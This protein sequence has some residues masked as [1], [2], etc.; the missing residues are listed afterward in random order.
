MLVVQPNTYFGDR[1]CE[2]LD[3]QTAGQSHWQTFEFAAAWINNSGAEKLLQSAHNFLARGGSIRA[4]VGLDFAS[5]SYEGLRSLLSLEDESV[6]I[7]TY[8]FYDENRACTFHPKVY[9]FSNSDVARLFVGSNNLTGGGLETNVEATLGFTSSLDDE[10]IRTAGQTLGAWRQDALSR[11][12]R[13]TLE[14]L[15]K[16]R[17]QGYVRTEEEIRISR[18]SAASPGATSREPLFG[19]SAASAGRRARSRASQEPGSRQAQGNVLEEVL[20]MRVRP[21]RNGGQFQI[22]MDVLNASFMNGATEVI[23]TDGSRR[24]IGYSIANGVRNTARFEAPE[25]RGMT[26]PVARFRRA[27]ASQS[28]S[29]GTVPLQYEI[30]DAAA[31]GEGARILR[32]LEEGIARPARTNLSELSRDETVLSK[33]DRSRAQWYRLDLN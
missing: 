10:T 24:Q 33:S 30:F 2:E 4:V 15:E 8:V 19:R 28:D 29:S 16:L 13:L 5:T 32:K 11:S 27:N 23:S 14:F 7:E 17:E 31:G 25:M 20:L 9:L 1:I 3:L 26:N 12:Q 22:S 18:T 21:R 6:D